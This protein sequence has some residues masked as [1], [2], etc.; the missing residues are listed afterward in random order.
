[1]ESAASVS[2]LS[3]L[4]ASASA[5]E[6]FFFS[7]LGRRDRRL[8]GACFSM[9]AVEMPRAAAAAPSSLTLG[10]ER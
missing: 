9:P 2:A 10:M 7:R 8:V 6:F 4:I 1:M 5:K 3:S